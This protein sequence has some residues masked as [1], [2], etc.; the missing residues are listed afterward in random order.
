ML[1]RESE[2]EGDCNH[3]SSVLRAP[4]SLREVLRTFAQNDLEAKRL[5]REAAMASCLTRGGARSRAVLV[6]ATI[7]CRRAEGKGF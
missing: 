4:K 7:L 5:R 3:G 1:S 6:L 2:I